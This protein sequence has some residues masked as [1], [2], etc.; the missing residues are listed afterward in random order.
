MNF[1]EQ[2]SFMY[3]NI[4]LLALWSCLQLRTR[5]G[6]YVIEVELLSEENLP[7]VE[8]SCQHVGGQIT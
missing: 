4:S 8:A 5:N 6:I 2:L 7:L 1:I 3:R